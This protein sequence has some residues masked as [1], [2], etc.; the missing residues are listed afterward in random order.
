MAKTKNMMILSN[1]KKKCPFQKYLGQLITHLG[2]EPI[3]FHLPMH[4]IIAFNHYAISEHAQRWRNFT[5]K[6]RVRTT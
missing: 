2:F 5:I 6:F 3:I 1:A 4:Y